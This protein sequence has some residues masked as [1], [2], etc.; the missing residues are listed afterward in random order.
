MRLSLQLRVFGNIIVVM[1][2]QLKIPTANKAIRDVYDEIYF[3][4]AEDVFEAEKAGKV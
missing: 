4:I 1:G 3:E 2:T